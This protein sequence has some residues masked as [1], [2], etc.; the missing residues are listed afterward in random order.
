MASSKLQIWNMALAE[1]PEARLDSLTDGFASEVL[2][3]QYQPALELLLEDHDY[4]FAIV[5]QALSQV[6][7]DRANEWQYAYRLPSNLARPRHLLPFSG[8]TVTG[9]AVY[10]WTGDGRALEAKVPLRISGGKLYG[11]ISG[12][13]LEYVMKNPGEA[14]MTAKFTRAFALELAAR[15]VM[16][17]KKDSK[18]Q[19]DL[20]RMAEVARE[21]AKADDMNRDRESPRDFMP[22]FMLA[23]MGYGDSL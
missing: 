10:S 22:D 12:A 13:V 23:R 7:N 1:L 15:A 17:I 8:D 16:P 9:S 5:R 4:D 6:V 21:R 18:R 19:G 2:E 14:V 20:I 3:D 11:N